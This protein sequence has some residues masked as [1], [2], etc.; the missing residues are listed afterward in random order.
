MASHFQ[1]SAPKLQ[2]WCMWGKA[3]QVTD[4]AERTTGDYCLPH[5]ARA[6]AQGRRNR[7]RAQARH[8]AEYARWDQQRK[9]AR[10][11]AARE[12]AA[13]ARLVAAAEQCEHCAEAAH[14]YRAARGF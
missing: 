7:E 14:A 8:D 2:A 11:A 6:D 4:L 10:D 12:A 1:P 13:L 5:Q 9:T 3:H